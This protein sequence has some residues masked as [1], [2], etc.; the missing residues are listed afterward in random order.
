[1]TKDWRGKRYWL[2]GASDGLGRALA[3]Q[4]SAAGA[5]LVLSARNASALAELAAALPGHCDVVPLD[6]T[7][8][9][10]VATAAAEIGPVDGMVYLAAT[11]WPMPATDWDTGRAITM[12]GTNYTGALHLVGAVLPGFLERDTGHVVLTSSLSAYRGLPGAIGYGASKA[13]VM[14]LAESLHLDL[15]RTGVQ[16]QLVNPG[17]IRTRLTDKNTFRMPFLMEADDAAAR[18]LR[19]M[20]T[21]RFAANFPWLFSTLFRVSRF[22]P[23]ALY[24]RLFAPR[25]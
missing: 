16:V 5:D 23:D 9:E 19:H 7:D 24:L 13:A 10:A 15:A 4:M 17:F 25:G 14:S 6:V 8:A 12:T 22:L 1:M 11:Y 3:R 18:M 20:G 21:R 2:V